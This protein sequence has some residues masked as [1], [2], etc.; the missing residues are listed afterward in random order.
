MEPRHEAMQKCIAIL[1]EHYDCVQILS[2]YTRDDRGTGFVKSGFGNIFGRIGMCHEFI[3]EAKSDT[4]SNALS[5]SI[6]PDEGDDWK[7]KA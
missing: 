7:E 6:K 4:I 2:S 1:G 5:E 3:E